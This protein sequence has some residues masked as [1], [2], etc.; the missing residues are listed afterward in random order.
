[1][2]LSLTNL[3]I[4]APVPVL[5]TG[6]RSQTINRKDECIMIMIDG[7]DVIKE[8]ASQAT[9][10]IW[11]LS[12]GSTVTSPEIAAL[13]SFEV[14]DIGR[15]VFDPTTGDIVKNTLES[16]S[17][18]L[19]TVISRIEVLARAYKGDLRGLMVKDSDW[20]GFV[21]RVSWELADI[22]KS[23]KYNLM[24]NYEAGKK[25]YSKEE[26]GFYP[27]KAH[28]KV[29]DEAVPIYTPFSIPIDQL[30]E[31]C[32]NEAEMSSIIGGIRAAARNTVELALQS[33]RHM[34]VQSG[35]AVSMAGTGTAINLLAAWQDE[36]GDT[37]EVTV[38]NWRTKPEFVAFCLEKI[39]ETRDNM[40][41]FGTA[42]NDGTV[43]VF[44]DGEYSRLIV[45][46][47]FDKL[48]RFGVKASTFNE[49]NLAIGEYET[50]TAWQ[51]WNGG[52]SVPKYDF[53]T[54]SKVM[55]AADSENKLGIGTDA[56]TANGVIAVLYDY[57]AMGISPYKR[58]TTTQ[59][60]AVGDYVNNFATV[61][62]G[63]MLDTTYPIVAFYIDEVE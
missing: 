59:Y 36:T 62:C 14:T 17:K 43:P 39:A 16:W 57:Y 45:L 19:V 63:T 8:S 32:K 6:A 54:V 2:G 44:T 56:F 30:R 15:N 41:T 22:L 46:N 52:S 55:V 3:Y 27:I 21:E 50:T 47:K 13:K 61:L 58:K 4:R 33:I 25:E 1:M 5:R 23:P 28:A 48:A 11:T 9:G 34:L 60:V 37:T 10:V 35:I 40:Q 53:E 38:S 31:A 49:K 51:S 7:V 26:L 24:A 20:G 12:D 42:F 29:Y 18:A